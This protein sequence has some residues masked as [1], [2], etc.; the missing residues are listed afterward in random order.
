MSSS[1]FTQANLKPV[2]KWVGGKRQLL[3]QLYDLMPANYNNYFEPFLGGGALFFSLAPTN[4]VVNDANAALIEMY[5]VIRDHPTELLNYLT[6]HAQKNSKEYYYTVREIDRNG[7]L[8]GL[9]KIQRVARLIFMLKVDF[10]GLYRVNSK[11]QFNVP[12][13]RYK[14]PKIANAENI[15]TVSAY[16]NSAKITFLNED[17]ADAVN[18]AA[19]NDFVY[20]DPPYIPVSVT[21]S[22][23]SYTADGFGMKD[24]ERLRDLFFAL[25]QKGVKVMLSNSDTELTRDLYQGANFHEVQ[26]S[27]SVNSDSSK[28]GKIGE[29]IITSY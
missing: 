3:Q 10:N 1:T 16:F 5:E 23:T 25:Q 9:N 27:R 29:L 21:S 2:I 12:Y 14:N 26:A 24:Q 13:G 17:F 19:K 20:F 6:V 8:G 11:G 4:A 15:M 18:T 7:Q 22:F 28:R